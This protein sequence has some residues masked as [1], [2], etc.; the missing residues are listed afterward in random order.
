MVE[1]I[2]AGYLAFLAYENGQSEELYL[3]DDYM[4]DFVPMSDTL[5][6][7][8]MLLEEVYDRITAFISRALFFG[9]D[10]IG[11]KYPARRRI[12]KILIRQ[13]LNTNPN[14]STFWTSP[15]DADGQTTITVRIKY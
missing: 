1:Y 4:P 5:E 7:D 15:S 13:A 10:R 3:N 9:L 11:I 14:V 12:F 2:P 6:L 8:G